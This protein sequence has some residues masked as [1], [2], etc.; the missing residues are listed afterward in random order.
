MARSSRSRFV[1]KNTGVYSRLDAQD[2]EAYDNS[3]RSINFAA[4]QE[5]I[6]KWMSTQGLSLDQYGGGRKPGRGQSGNVSQQP[7]PTSSFNRGLYDM[8][9][10]EDKRHYLSSTHKLKKSISSSPSLTSRIESSMRNTTKE[11]KPAQPRLITKYVDSDTQRELA[12]RGDT[13]ALEGGKTTA[14]IAKQQRLMK[15]RGKLF[16]KKDSLLKAWDDR[17]SY[18]N[19]TKLNY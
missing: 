12:G 13:H 3:L 9:T 8:L 2:K 10:T 11:M 5:F 16:N 14:Y 6:K 15:K 17:N 1:K 19:G 18:N 7:T 4:K